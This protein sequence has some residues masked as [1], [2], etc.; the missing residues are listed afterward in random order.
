MENP[1][2]NMEHH[3]KSPINGLLAEKKHKNG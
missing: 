3:G 1:K 2:K